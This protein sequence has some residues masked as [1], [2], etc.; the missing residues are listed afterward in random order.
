MAR[1][2]ATTTRS[3][4]LLFARSPGGAPEADAAWLLARRCG[5]RVV[6]VREPPELG[7]GVGRIPGAEVVPRSRLARHAVRWSLDE[8]AVVEVLLAGGFHAHT[9]VPMLVPHAGGRGPFVHHPGVAAFARAE[10]RDFLLDAWA[11][12]SGGPPRA[13][14]TF[15]QGT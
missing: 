6:D 4:P 2:G 15:P 8:A 3:S 7:A 10:T 13:A 5:V 11:S 1:V 12:P 9:R 14:S